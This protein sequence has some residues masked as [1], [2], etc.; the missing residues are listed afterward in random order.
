M[1]DSSGCSVNPRRHL[2]Y[3]VML[4]ASLSNVAAQ[5][6]ETL[7]VD[8]CPHFARLEPPR[9]DLG[10]QMQEHSFFMNY[11]LTE[12]GG[13]TSVAFRQEDPRPSSPDTSS[14]AEEG[15]DVLASLKE[16]VEKKMP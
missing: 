14:G 6:A 5:A 7:P 12:S 4:L 10:D 13:L 1:S 16:L 9:N 15:P 2:A 3:R 8:K 11:E